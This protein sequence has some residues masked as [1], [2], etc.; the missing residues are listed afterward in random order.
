MISFSPQV[1]AAESQSPDLPQSQNE[2]EETIMSVVPETD[3]DTQSTVASHVSGAAEAMQL[4]TALPES[5]VESREQAPSE[6]VGSRTSPP[7]IPEEDTSQVVSEMPTQMT[8]V[9]QSQEAAQVGKSDSTDEYVSPP[10]LSIK[11]SQVTS[12]EPSVTVVESMG[13]ETQAEMQ[14]SLSSEA[15]TMAETMS[16]EAEMVR[17]KSVESREVSLE[18]SVYEIERQASTDVSG[19]DSQPTP[20]VVDSSEPSSVAA[21]VPSELDR[22]TAVDTEPMDAVSELRE[23]SREVM[24]EREGDDDEVVTEEMATLG[25]ADTTQ[26]VQGEGVSWLQCMH[27]RI[28]THTLVT[29]MYLQ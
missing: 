24:D 22:D 4:N 13:K 10:S 21:G 17:R 23:E 1:L 25:Q 28:H 20:A 15:A 16:S 7:V 26:R 29:Y 19:S 27:T 6:D 11:P 9:T 5:V 18:P 14:T 12:Q 8:Q 2:E 3:L